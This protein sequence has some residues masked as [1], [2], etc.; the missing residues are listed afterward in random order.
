[1]THNPSADDTADIRNIA[2]RIKA[3]R[4]INSMSQRD[5]ADFLKINYRTVQDLENGKNVPSGRLIHAFID[6]GYDANWILNGVGEMALAG[7]GAPQFPLAHT[8]NSDVTTKIDPLLKNLDQ[9]NL[10]FPA[11]IKHFEATQDDM[12]PTVL[13]RDLVIYDPQKKA[14]EVNGLY[15]LDFQGKSCVRRLQQGLNDVIHILCD[16]TFYR[17]ES[18][19][20]RNLAVDGHVIGILRRFS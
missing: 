18:A 19:P 3:I 9:N 6:A 16:N 15:V 1:M 7:Q 2:R 8:A 13:P 10:G 12:A 5:F 11:H 14:V 17:A 4:Q 20:R